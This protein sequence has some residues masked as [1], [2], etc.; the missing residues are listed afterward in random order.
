MHLR[1]LN[2]DWTNKLHSHRTLDE[3]TMCVCTVYAR[4]GA[5]RRGVVNVCLWVRRFFPSYLSFRACI[6]FLFLSFHSHV[7]LVSSRLTWRKF[8]EGCALYAYFFYDYSHSHFAC[9]KAFRC[10]LRSFFVYFRS[11]PTTTQFAMIIVIVH[12]S[13]TTNETN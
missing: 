2:F 4:C 7:I 3:E 9:T 11:P 5:V 8:P 6:P 1:S 12:A 10:V 13:Q